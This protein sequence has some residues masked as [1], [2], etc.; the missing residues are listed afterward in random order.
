M[1]TYAHLVFLGRKKNAEIGLESAETDCCV[2]TDLFLLALESVFWRQI[3]ILA[4][5][6][7][8]AAPSTAS[9]LTTSS[10][11]LILTLSLSS[12]VESQ[13]LA[14]VDCFI[15]SHFTLPTRNDLR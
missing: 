4:R 8:N 13:V 1:M 14:I 12:L 10:A 3:S 11:G 9:A 15:Q 7:K 6:E 5:K 2:I